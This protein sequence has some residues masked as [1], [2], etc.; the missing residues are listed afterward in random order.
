[1]FENLDA[2]IEQALADLHARTPRVNVR[3]LH[4]STYAADLAKCAA[5]ADSSQ[6]F[7]EL[8]AHGGFITNNY[9]GQA[10]ADYLTVEVDLRDGSTVVRAFRAN[11]KRSA[12]GAGSTV[13]YRL[14]SLGQARGHIVRP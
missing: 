1:M 14:K 11:A 6:V 3:R 9:P 4:S 2:R 7:L 12:H 8:E 13:R 10:A 5:Q